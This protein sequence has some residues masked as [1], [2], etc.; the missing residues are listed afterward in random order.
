MSKQTQ[1]TEFINSNPQSVYTTAELCQHIGCSLPT[2]LK[3]I[4]ENADRFEKQSRGTYK[5]VS[6][7]TNIMEAGSSETSSTSVV[8]SYSPEEVTMITSSLD[9]DIP[10]PTFDW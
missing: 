5:I 10:K 4:K 2:I 8:T 9:N 6:S 1:I 7:N 3:F